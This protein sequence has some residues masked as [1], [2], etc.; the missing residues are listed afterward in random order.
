MPRIIKV[1]CIPAFAF[2][3]LAAVDAP[4]TDAANGISSQHGSVGISASHRHHKHPVI[5]R[6]IRRIQ[7]I[8]P[9]Y[10]G[11]HFR[12]HFY[13]PHVYYPRPRL[14]PR[15]G[16]LDYVPGYWPVYPGHWH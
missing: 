11:I 9:I 1:L 12:R 2:A 7:P 4:S 10:G 8:H 5:R 16:H 15:Y 6:T 14:V 3:L 13:P